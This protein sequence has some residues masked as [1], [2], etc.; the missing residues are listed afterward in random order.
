MNSR[1][2]HTLVRGL[3]A[4]S[5]GLGTA[6]LAAPEV[7]NH[8]I[9]VRDNARTRQV[10]RYLGGAREVAAGV[11]LET[12]IKPNAWLWARVAGDAL[13]L[14]MLGSVLSRARR[15][16]AKRRAALA[17]AAVAGV[18]V[19]DLVAA[20]LTSRDGA[21]PGIRAA[22][23][24]TINRSVAEVYAAW[25]QLENLPRFMAHLQEVRPAGEGR[26][27]WRAAG[28]AGIDVE[29]EA[30]ITSE[31]ADEHLAWRSV[32][33]ATVRN[34]GQVDFRPA[35]GGHGT[36]VRVHLE[37]EPP[38]G[39]LGTAVAKLFGEEPDQQV[40]DDLRR[41]KQLLETGEVVRSEG[42]P[43]G[44]ESPAYLVQRPARPVDA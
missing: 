6:Q 34:S 17:T 14:S 19:A 23:R 7:V 32:G 16:D 13:D 39:A 30:E 10:Q 4:F 3:G 26:T 15:R 28:P 40:R 31:R 11:G 8:L 44:A 33:D 2:T 36:E 20:V 41:F 38:A 37:Y 21:R 18:A 22:A 29:W 12:R 5:I 35:P 1:V 42:S 43:G 25:R 9:G 27:Y 24:I